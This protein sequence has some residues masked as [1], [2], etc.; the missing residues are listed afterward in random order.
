MLLFFQLAVQVEV[1][2]ATA[3]AAAAIVVPAAFLFVLVPVLLASLRPLGRHCCGGGC[4]INSSSGVAAVTTLAQSTKG[5][6]H[7]FSDIRPSSTTEGSRTKLLCYHS[8][9]L[10]AI[11]RACPRRNISASSSSLQQEGGG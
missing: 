11:T 5:A 9:L 2:A 4:Y 6:R 8:G 1:V 3:V 7:S 10:C